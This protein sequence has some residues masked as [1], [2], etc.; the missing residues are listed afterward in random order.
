MA[1]ALPARTADGSV[2]VIL[3]VVTTPATGTAGLA[4][5]AA[6]FITPAHKQRRAQ[7]GSSAVP[8][9]EHGRAMCARAAGEVAPR[10]RPSGVAAPIARPRNR[11]SHSDRRCRAPVDRSTARPPAVSNQRLAA[12]VVRHKTVTHVSVQRRAG[13]GSMM[14]VIGTLMGIARLEHAA[15]TSASAEASRRHSSRPWDAS[16][17]DGRDDRRPRRDR[18][19][20]ERCDSRP[21]ASGTWITLRITIPINRIRN[22]DR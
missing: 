7:A 10:E 22:R 13:T 11:R 2:Q 18:R 14:V 16:A 8:A 3:R 21:A 17:A 6:G 19:D 4:G 1:A 9:L 20:G 15:G 5:R 12:P